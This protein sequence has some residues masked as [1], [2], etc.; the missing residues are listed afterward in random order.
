MILPRNQEKSLV[1]GLQCWKEF[2]ACRVHLEAVKG[3]IVLL[4]DQTMRQWLCKV[5]ES[6]A[7]PTSLGI[8]SALIQQLVFYC[9]PLKPFW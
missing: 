5:K 4:S 7:G 6:A 1:Y 3:S 8:D 2:P 9:G